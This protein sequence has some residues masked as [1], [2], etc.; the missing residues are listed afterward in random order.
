M[1]FAE[2][3]EREEALLQIEEDVDAIIVVGS[4][5]SSNTMKLPNQSILRLM[6]F[7]NSQKKF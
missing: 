4:E 5:K 6:L 2:Q 1:K 3:R 7:K